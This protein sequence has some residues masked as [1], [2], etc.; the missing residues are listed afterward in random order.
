MI[1]SEEEFIKLVEK[2][3]DELPD[4]IQETMNNV[5]I[6]V[7]DFPTKEQLGKVRG[8]NEYSLL[9]LFEGYVQSKR[10]NFGAVLP[11]KITLFRVP[12]MQA[13]ST[14]QQCEE[15]VRNTVKHEI[16]HHFGSDEKGARKAEKRKL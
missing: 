15:L 5:A 2:A 10:L 11:D 7:V 3:L 12:I 1:I 9:G 8:N 16:A 13:C 4:H 14:H 6:L